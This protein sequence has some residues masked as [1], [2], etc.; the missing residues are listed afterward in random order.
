MR[1]KAVRAHSLHV[2]V[3]AFVAVNLALVSAKAA[4][5]RSLCAAA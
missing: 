5:T 3:F 4:K 2:R 1:V